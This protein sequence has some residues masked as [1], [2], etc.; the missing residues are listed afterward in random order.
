MDKR[1]NAH[2]GYSLIEMLVAIMIFSLVM[3][4]GVNSLLSLVAANR[5]VQ[6]IQSATTDLNFAFENMSRAMRTGQ[7]FAC[8][9]A[10]SPCSSAP[11]LSDCT[12]GGSS[13]SFCSQDGEEIVYR[14]VN[15]AGGDYLERTVDGGVPARLTAPEISLA[16]FRF[17]MQGALSDDA[18]QPTITMAARARTGADERADTEV[19]VQTSVTQ[20]LLD[21]PPPPP[22]PPTPA[23]YANCAAILTAGASTGD[24]MYTI[25][26]DGEGGNDPFDVFCDMTTDGGGWTL[27]VNEPASASGAIPEV[28][29]LGIAMRGRLSNARISSLLAASTY[30]YNNV[31]V[32]LDGTYTAQVREFGMRVENSAV[33]AYRIPSVS[34]SGWTEGPNVAS[35][36][37]SS[38]FHFYNGSNNGS[39]GYEAVSGWRFAINLCS[40]PDLACGMGYGGGCSGGR[41]GQVWIK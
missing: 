24:G 33:N 14:L 10:G 21:I 23:T 16:F 5:K 20:R 38:Q 6:A 8:P 12:S 34:C 22:S 3:I 28:S 40:A 27:V 31:R 17:Y 25:D 37:S 1:H 19:A 7:N 18:V 29:S 32:E 30:A 4:V 26:P 15:D 2:T 9:A 13:V 11:D 41:I 36:F 39:A 35:S